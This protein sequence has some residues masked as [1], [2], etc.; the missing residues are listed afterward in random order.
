[1]DAG[2]T[3]VFLAFGG[4]VL[5]AVGLATVACRPLVDLDLEDAIA[6]SG[7]L[8]GEAPPG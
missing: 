7:T 5:A 4:F 8:V 6:R 2:V 1:L 3:G